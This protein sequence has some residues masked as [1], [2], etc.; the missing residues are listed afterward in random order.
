MSGNP[1]I[2]FLETSFPFS[3]FLRKCAT[4]IKI[5]LLHTFNLLLQ[6]HVDQLNIQRILK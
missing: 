3:A 6:Q 1:L 5:F 4:I 2:V